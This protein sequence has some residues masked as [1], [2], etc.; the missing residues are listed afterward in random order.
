VRARAFGLG[1]LEFRK[2]ATRLGE[3]GRRLAA[4]RHP[5]VDPAP[6]HDRK[7][8][9]R[10]ERRLGVFLAALFRSASRAPATGGPGWPVDVSS[11]NSAATPATPPTAPG[12]LDRA[13]R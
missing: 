2:S 3:L 5:D 12:Y 6:S 4:G 8:R 13:V 7:Y 10:R 9:A 11:C 1:S